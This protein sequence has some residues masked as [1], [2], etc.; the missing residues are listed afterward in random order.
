MKNHRPTGEKWLNGEILKSIGQVSFTVRM[1]DGIL[2]ENGR[3]V[4]NQFLVENG[5]FCRLK[6]VTAL[7][8][9]SRATR[10]ISGSMPP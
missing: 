2:F 7:G 8:A 10:T 4:E 5:R 9:A 6:P 3:F 1:S